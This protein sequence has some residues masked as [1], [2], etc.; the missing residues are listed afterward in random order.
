MDSYRN[1]CRRRSSRDS[2]CGPA[3]CLASVSAPSASFFPASEFDEGRESTPDHALT[4]ERDRLRIH[5]LGE[6]RVAH[7]LFVD[8]VTSDARLIHN[9]G[10]HH[11]LAG[12]EFYALGE[13][14][15]LSHLD[16]F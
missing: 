1:R 10:E 5:H 8:A 16:V 4:I 15:P 3:R 7:H 2:D 9:P 6:T 14:G 12:L 13:G 11:D